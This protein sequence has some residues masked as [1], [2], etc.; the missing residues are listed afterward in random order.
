MEFWF[1][2]CV[3]GLAVMMIELVAVVVIYVRKQKERK[4]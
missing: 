4:Y 1:G 3:G 2:F